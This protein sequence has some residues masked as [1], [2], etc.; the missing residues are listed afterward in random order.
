MDNIINLRDLLNHEIL[1]LHS[2][3]KQIIDG[4]PGMIDK[5]TNSELKMALSEHLEVTKNHKERLEKIKGLL[6]NSETRPEAKDD[7]FFSRLFGGSGEQKCKG[8]E[9]LIKEGEKMLSMDM[10]SEVR[11]AAII[12]GAQKIE[13]YE[14][15]GYGTAL[16]YARQL[17]LT[18]ISN[19]LEQTLN[20]EY[21]AD[22]SL[23]ELAIG[24]VNVDAEDA[25]DIDDTDEFDTDED[26]NG[27]SEAPTYQR[28]AGLYNNTSSSY[29]DDLGA[30]NRSAL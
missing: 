27:T 19:L 14:I 24:K 10:S 28:N 23:T 3:E 30:G 11:D 21:E 5:A 2:A 7:N 4:L 13:H 12:A 9:G 8:T 18:E 29:T 1:D 25:I 17:G 15:A 26:I 22:D 16:A 6:K 20:E